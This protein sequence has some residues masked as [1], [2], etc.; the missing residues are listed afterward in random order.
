MSS[1]PL[2][3]PPNVAGSLSHCVSAEDAVFA[4]EGEVFGA[5]G[6]RQGNGGTALSS[7]RAGS[8]LATPL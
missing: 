5:A 8:P 4:V 3:S 7:P 6:G 1:N 2:L